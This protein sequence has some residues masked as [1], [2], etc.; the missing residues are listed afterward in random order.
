MKDCTIKD[1]AKAAGVS[2]STVSKALNGTG[3]I[4][5][6]TRDKIIEIAKEMN[7]SP[8]SIAVSMVVKKSKTIAV[9]I[10]YISS[11]FYA[12]VIQGV[13]NTARQY[14]YSTLVY[15]SDE[16]EEKERDLFRSSLGKF[17]DGVVAVSSVNKPDIYEKYLKPVVLIDRNVDDS[18]LDCVMIDNF[19]STNILAKRLISAGHKRIAYLSGSLDTNVGRDRLMGFEQAMHYA[20]IPVDYSLVRL[21]SWHEPFGYQFM[22]EYVKMNDTQKPTAIISSNESICDGLLIAGRE[23]GII[24]GEEV[25][26]VSVDDGILATFNEPKITVIQRETTGMGAMAMSILHEK[27]NGKPE[28]AQFKKIILPVKLVERGSVKDLNER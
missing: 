11:T 16:S 12:N 26:L 20:G 24:F 2:I 25:S 19:E 21:E 28:T 18:S 22:H 9:M 5:T 14:G 4:N 27:L 10:P 15:C 1:V 3:I 17:V 7:Y 13:E 6:R 23:L 8:N